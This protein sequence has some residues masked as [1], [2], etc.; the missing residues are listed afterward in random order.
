MKCTISKSSFH[1]NDARSFEEMLLIRTTEHWNKYTYKLLTCR[2]D[3][4]IFQ[5]DKARKN[6]DWNE[7][8]QKDCG[9]FSL[10]GGL[11]L[12][13]HRFKVFLV[14]SLLDCGLPE[15]KMIPRPNQTHFLAPRLYLFDQIV[16]GCNTA[17]GK[18]PNCELKFHMLKK[19][20]GKRR[21]LCS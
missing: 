19:K 21:L 15:M 16:Y 20:S 18:D 2:F 17:H 4:P 11:F 3:F 7:V 10:R 6:N 9:L 14:N 1:M 5:S 12:R 8:L 13:S